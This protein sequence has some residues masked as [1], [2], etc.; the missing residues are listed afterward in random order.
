MVDDKIET[1]KFDRNVMIVNIKN[2][3][4]EELESDKIYVSQ[5][6]QYL[7]IKSVLDIV[8]DYYIIEFEEVTDSYQLLIPVLFN[9]TFDYEKGKLVNVFTGLNKVD[10]S[11]IYLKYL[12][13]HSKE[14]EEKLMNHNGFV[15]NID[16]DTFIIYK[17]KV[18]IKW[19]EDYKL[20][21]E[22]Q[23]SKLSKVGKSTI[24]GYFEK[25]YGKGVKL[26]M[27]QIFSQ[28]LKL[29]KEIEIKIGE[30]LPINAELHSKL[31]LDI[32]IT[33]NE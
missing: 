33:N 9:S 11:H 3:E 13:C 32:M 23:Y 26:K 4:N 21:L 24:L 29:R 20:L 28:S 7:P 15:E 6:K 30:S 10:E 18:P 14:V 5:L 27:E 12:K 17:F 1:I 8:G 22:G 25:E 16:F 31:N 2:I 19:L